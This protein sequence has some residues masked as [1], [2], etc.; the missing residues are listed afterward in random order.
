MHARSIV[1][2]L[3]DSPRLDLQFG[4]LF[5]VLALVVTEICVFECL[6]LIGL[7][8]CMFSPKSAPVV[9][10]AADFSSSVVESEVKSS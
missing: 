7:Q 3:I 1:L 2:C 10:I 8:I 6:A 4:I 5:V 9:Y